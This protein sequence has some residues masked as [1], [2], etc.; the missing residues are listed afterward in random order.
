M[1]INKSLSLVLLLFIVFNTFSQSKPIEKRDQ[2]KALKIAYITNQ[3]QLTADEA[4]KFWPIYNTYD[5]KQRELKYNKIRST[6]NRYEN[7]DLDK[8]SEK[9]A[10]SLLKQLENSEDELYDLRKKFNLDLM[11]VL[12]SIKII[13]LKKSEEGFNK[14]LFKQ[15]KDKLLSK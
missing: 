6:M 7:G 1:K 13:K 10:S 11:D 8:L 14:K 5:A 4:T 12:P 9:E 15:Y 3:L 2:I